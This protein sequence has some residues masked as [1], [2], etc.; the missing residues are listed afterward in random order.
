DFRFDLF[1]KDSSYLQL[2]STIGAQY[3]VSATRTGKV[4]LQFQNTTVLSGGI[5]TIAI[6]VEK[7]LPVNID[8]KAV[9]VGL[10]YEVSNT[11]YRLNPSTGN[12]YSFTSLIGLKTIKRNNQVTAIKDPLFNY[13]SLYDSIK[14][15]SYQLKL[16]GYAAKYFPLGKFATFKT[17]VRTGL[18][19]TPEIFRNELYQI[20]GYSIL[21]G[22]NEE[23]IYATRY[24]VATA[25]YRI[26]VGANSYFFFFS[27]GGLVKNKYQSVNTNNVFISAGLG[28][29]FETKVGLLNVSFA[30]GKRDDVAFNVRQAAKLHFGYINYF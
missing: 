24:A 8:V 29:L 4:F 26:L 23:S 21:R 11:N 3:T 2:N 14:T 1:K 28:I 18:L 16:A 25:E 7:K 30:L 27:D 19:F 15:K 12:E 20:G 9:S 6:K 5:D 22:F 13:A 17:A 10:Q